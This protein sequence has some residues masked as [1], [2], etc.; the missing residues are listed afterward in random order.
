MIVAFVSRNA[1]VKEAIDELGLEF[2]KDDW[3]PGSDLADSL[4]AFAQF[5]FVCLPFSDVAVALGTADALKIARSEQAHLE[6]NLAR[7]LTRGVLDPAA[8]ASDLTLDAVKALVAAAYL[9]FLGVSTVGDWNVQCTTGKLAALPIKLVEHV[10]LKCKANWS[11][12]FQVADP[13]AA[14]AP[15]AAGGAGGTGK[16]TAARGSLFIRTG[17]FCKWL[18]GVHPPVSGRLC[19]F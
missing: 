5:A 2:V 9:S 3:A 8:A 11:G 4:G 7:V 1:V 16:A 19:R 12:P 10:V 14:A 17:L 18:V 15:A 13:R 6:D